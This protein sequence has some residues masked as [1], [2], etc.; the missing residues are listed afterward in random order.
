[1]IKNIKKEAKH[2]SPNI[3]KQFVARILRESGFPPNKKVFVRDQH[4]KIIVRFDKNSN[5][6]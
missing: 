5:Y 4:G 6:E 3:Q 1:M 2:L